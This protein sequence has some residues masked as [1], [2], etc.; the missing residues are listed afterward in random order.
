MRPTIKDVQVVVCRVMGVPI[1]AMAHSCRQQV[2]AVPRQFAM[3]LAREMTQQ[4]YPLLG[5]HFGGRDHSTVI[6]AYRKM[7]RM[8]ACDLKTH[9]L[10]E[11]LRAEIRMRVAQRVRFTLPPPL[12]SIVIINN[13]MNVVGTLEGL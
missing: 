1:H 5:R 9:D 10:M 8:E 11:R 4:S 6:W 7:L 2:W 3:A 12:P 13:R